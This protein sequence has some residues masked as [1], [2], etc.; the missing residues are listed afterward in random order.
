MTPTL[1]RSQPASEKFEEREARLHKAVRAY[2]LRLTGSEWEADDLAQDTW[3]KSRPKLSFEGQG[4]PNAEAFMYR[5]AKNSWIDWR[6]RESRLTRLPDRM[7]L[8]ADA[9]RVDGIAN[10]EA[11]FQSLLRH[12]SR[13]QLASFLLRDLFGYTTEETSEKLAITPGAVKAALFRARKSLAEVRQELLREEQPRQIEEAKATVRALASAYQAA[14][15]EGLLRMLDTRA[16]DATAA[17]A[18]AQTALIGR[19]AM[20]TA[21]EAGTVYAGGGGTPSLMM[22]WVA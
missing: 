6:R 10:I 5:I 14:D 15:I 7:D 12:L 2:C 11:M 18:I 16:D 20:Q 21:Q 9:F 8:E 3:I 17:A 1:K 4:H 19:P 13:Q 22:L